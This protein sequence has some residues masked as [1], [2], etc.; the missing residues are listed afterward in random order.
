[1]RVL[2]YLLWDW[3]SS[4]GG[5]G[6]KSCPLLT[7][8]SS[9]MGTWEGVILQNVLNHMGIIICEVTKAKQSHRPW[10]KVND[11]FF[12]S[13]NFVHCSDEHYNAHHTKQQQCERSITFRAI[14]ELSCA[15]GQALKSYFPYGIFVFFFLL[16]LVAPIQR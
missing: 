9:A 6:R 2:A 11:F 13:S 7:Q 4:E 10:L 14:P 16:L 1:M 5:E 15:H 3:S 8:L 12:L